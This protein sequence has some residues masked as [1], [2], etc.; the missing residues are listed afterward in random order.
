MVWIVRKVRFRRFGLRYWEIRVRR[1][2]MREI[3]SSYKYNYMKWSLENKN[4]E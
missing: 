2:R 1:E 4:F 3:V